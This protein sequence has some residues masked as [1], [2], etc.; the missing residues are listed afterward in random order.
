[1]GADQDCGSILT[2]SLTTAEQVPD[3]VLAYRE[4]GFFHVR[5]NPV[6]GGPLLFGEG[7]PGHAAFL[8]FAYLAEVG[9]PAPQPLAVYHALVTSASAQGA[10]ASFLILACTAGTAL[11]AC[12]EHAARC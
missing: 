5:G 12:A 11:V 7:E 3:G 10:S 4:P 8:L 6:F 9:D 1:M 2:L